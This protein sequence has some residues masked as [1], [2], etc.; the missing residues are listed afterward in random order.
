[1]RGFPRSPSKHPIGLFCDASLNETD[2][3]AARAANAGAMD[4][5]G[6]SDFSSSL[7]RAFHSR[8]RLL[9]GG[10]GPVC[11]GGG[12]G[13]SNWRHRLAVWSRARDGRHCTAGGHRDVSQRSSPTASR[14]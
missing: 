6:A 4:I 8:D 13:E 3:W 2:M 12:A 10:R 1:M 9:V 11:V 14:A 5:I 7:R